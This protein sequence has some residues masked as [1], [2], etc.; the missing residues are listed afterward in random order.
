MTPF[1][2][3]QGSLGR[4]RVLG[5]GLALGALAGAGLAPGR[6]RAAEAVTYITPFGFLSTFAPV[7]NAAAG[8]HFERQGLDVQIIGGNGSASALQ[9]V[10]AGRAL[11]TRVGSVDV[12]RA[13]A[14]QKVPVVAVGT[15]IQGSVYSLISPEA[16]PVKGPADLP[17]KT[18]G[19]IS[20]GGVT[21][22]LLNL[23]LIRAGIDPALVKRQAV[24]NNP[25]AYGLLQ[26]GRIDAMISSTDVLVGLL[27]AKAPIHHLNTDALV[28]MPGEVYVATRE[29]VAKRADAIV[30]FLRGVK[31]SVEEMAPERL[32]GVVARLAAKYD[33]P[34]EDKPEVIRGVLERQRTD[35]YKDGP[36]NLLRNN[37][38][39]W[40]DAVRLMREAGLGD[41]GAPE[42]LYTNELVARI[43]A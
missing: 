19:I 6:A 26:A 28:P 32:D 11:L 10:L 30:A 20:V 4:R 17:G 25:G 33:M 24:G 9:Q 22:N 14:T 5:S 21:E 29:S 2:L 34:G 27:T 31:A 8:G 35:W 41:A 23:M 40:T 15:I 3:K 1:D 37:P 12:I 39:R 43:H 36:Q 13:V 18:V 7:L 16:K 38:Q 42:T